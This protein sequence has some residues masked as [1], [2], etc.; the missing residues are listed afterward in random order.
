MTPE[1]GRPVRLS[2]E[3][4]V[5]PGRRLARLEGRVFFANE[6]L[7]GETVEAEILR[8]HS[9]F[10]EARTTAILT[11]SPRRIPVRCGHYLACG[12]YQGLPYADQLELK[13]A[14]FREMFRE[15]GPALPA[16]L[17]IVASPRE[18]HYRNKIRFSLRGS[19]PETFLAYHAPGSREAF[20]PTD[21]R[22]FLATD[23]SC[24]IAGAVLTA[25]RERGIPDLG[26]IEVRES[27]SEGN[28]LL[29]LFWRTRRSE[30][31]LAAIVPALSPRF[32]VSGIVSWT[33]GRG[34][35]SVAFTEWGADALTE[36]TGEMVYEIGAGSFFQINGAI[37]PLVLDAVIAA[38]GLQG[39][40]IVADVYGGVG[41]FGLALANSAGRVFVV[42]SSPDNIRRL[43]SNI[44]GNGLDNVEV[45][46][47]P[48]ENWMTDLA[49]RGLDL[50]MLDPP[51]KGL[52]PE[53]VRALNDRPVGK[54][55]Y[56]SCNPAT[57]VRD[58]GLLGPTYSPASVRLFD[59]FPQTPHIET[60]AV[61]VPN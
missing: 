31:A 41:T 60:L 53:V 61:L 18:W 6:G 13:K 29:N 19:G 45:C 9:S 57:L 51:R 35:R 54:I 2:I 26:E 48:A 46:R 3:K 56:L 15:P 40:E 10:V 21:G 34:G 8:E 12:S 43:K 38:A 42:E 16:E 22:C 27:R 36:R 55:L 5:Y 7:P 1:S 37:L 4:I 24:A 23:H 47:A 49:G 11:P 25:V 32:P 20:L 30:A 44:A 52:A 50:V 17:E 14:Q 39:T 58:L 28:F 59:F 33:P